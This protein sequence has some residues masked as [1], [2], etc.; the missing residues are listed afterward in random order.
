MV[1]VRKTQQPAGI[2]GNWTILARWASLSAWLLLVVSTGAFLGGY[3]ML[4]GSLPILDGTVADP[5]ISSPVTVSR[6]AFGAPT[7]EATDR[8][9]AAFALGFLHAQDRFFQMDLLRRSAAGELA[10]MFGPAALAHDEDVRRFRFRWRARLALSRL[11][12]D[13]R[14]LLKKYV[15]GVN[16]GLDRLRV[17]PFEYLLLRLSPKPWSEEDTLLVVW[18]MYLTLQGDQEPRQ[19]ALMWLREHTTSEQLAFLLPRS[20]VFDAPIDADH[21]TTAPTNR[22]DT[23]PSWFAK[24]SLLAQTPRRR[25]EA[26]GSNSLA[27]A[28]GR[29]ADGRAIV[30]NDM[31]LALRIP[32]T[33]YRA[34][35]RYRASDGPRSLV[36]MTLPGEPLI[37]VGSNG[38][39]AW[40]FT[41]SYADCLEV[42]DAVPDP[43]SASRMRVNGN[44]EEVAI[45]TEHIVVRDASS[46][47][48]QIRETR[49]GP[50][51]DLDGRYAITH[52][53]ALDRGAVNLNL[54]AMEGAHDVEESISIG[55][56][57]GIPAQNMVVADD[58]G[59]IAWSIAG[60][61]PG[62]EASDMAAKDLV[63]SKPASWTGLQTPERYPKLLDPANAAIWTANSRVL[64]GPAQELIG[65]GGH[66]LGARTTQIRDD[67]LSAS[68]LD[69]QSI[70]KIS[71]DDRA[72]FMQLWREHALR[73]LT[74]T[75]APAGSARAEFRRLLQNGWTGRA[76]TD[77]AGYS[78]AKAYLDA[79]YQE[80]FGAVDAQLGRLPGAPDFNL[81]ST[82]WPAVLL[83]FLDRG[84]ASAWLPAGKTWRDVQL[85]AV[86]RAIQKLTVDGH[87]LQT[88]TW[89][90]LNT[91]HISHPIAAAVPV[92]HRFLTA[93]ALQLSGDKDMP[94][95]SR[96][97]FGASERM[98]VSPGDERH[99]LFDMPGGQS[100]H[101][102]S[103]FFLADHEAWA[104]G[105]PLKLLPGPERYRLRFRPRQ[106]GV[107]AD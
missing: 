23:P 14:V 81:V 73:V 47:D 79:L 104:R 8:G 65:D 5:G 48:V 89:G 90:R 28:A 102:L 40:G 100:G 101:P 68:E 35:L 45:T 19:Y 15:A 94:R 57:A 58:S 20:S 7:I 64:A 41:N 93:P 92:L 106:E 62:R 13:Q 95:V 3:V 74:Q 91:S 25:A 76:D 67:I 105:E 72:L 53:V 77:S 78:L 83:E 46:V 50:V 32:N 12:G 85:A 49:L 82:R 9:D 80:V 99:A 33:W 22:P 84:P 107:A 55:A 66:D 26:V 60:A 98:V 69:Q 30:S 38:H 16:A 61:L 86:D 36:G 88:Q 11:P 51:R 75:A 59:R 18:A 1:Q 56:V 39:V 71:L 54:V 21:V 44:W 2:D 96:S 42:L 6:D 29:T 37:V 63:T 17:R 27:V 10:E 24:P 43:H 52:W 97:D 70:F 103:P 4:R 31:H 87:A 34:A